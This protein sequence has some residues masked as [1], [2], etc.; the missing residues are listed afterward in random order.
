LNYSSKILSK[1]HSLSRLQKRT[2]CNIDRF[3]AQLE[4]SHKNPDFSRNSCWSTRA[5][6]LW[7]HCN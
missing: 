4:N 3:L 6:E 7:Y 2:S 1:A 5:C